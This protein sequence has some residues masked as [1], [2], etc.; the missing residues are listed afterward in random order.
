MVVVRIRWQQWTASKHQLLLSL[1]K[2]DAFRPPL[3]KVGVRVL[4]GDQQRL[5]QADLES[6][7]NVALLRKAF[8]EARSLQDDP[9]VRADVVEESLIY[10]GQ[11]WL[12]IFLL[13]M[14]ACNIQ[15]TSYG[16]VHNS[17]Q[18]Q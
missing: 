18:G 16:T 3:A 12:I 4:E 5:D 9:E 2:P 7:D 11:L 8:A 1:P 14:I 15:Q 10:L 17:S 6:L 13:S